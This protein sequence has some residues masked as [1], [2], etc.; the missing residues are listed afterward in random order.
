MNKELE[1]GQRVR[2][3]SNT[4][5]ATGDYNPL[6]CFGTVVESPDGWTGV[7]WD[8]GCSNAYKPYDE[9]LIPVEEE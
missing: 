1:I 8:N 9:D 6:D 3:S 5:W 7:E 2:L 4:L